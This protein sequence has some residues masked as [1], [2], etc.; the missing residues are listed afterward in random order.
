MY[1]D[2][3][4]ER[5]YAA[6][7]LNADNESPPVVLVHGAAMD[8]TVWVYHTR[9]FLH[10]GHNV[11]A[12]D[13]PG[14]GLSG[15]EPRRGIEDMASWLGG[16]LDTLGVGTVAL[17]GHSMGALVALELASRLGTRVSRLA[18]LGAAVPMAVSPEL[19]AE[20]EQDSVTARDMMVIW[21]H[22]SAA[23]IGGNAVAGIAIINSALRLLER[24]R[25]GVLFADLSAC[26][27][28]VAGMQAAA[29]VSAS[30]TLICGQE[31]RMTP[32]KAAR[33]LA[34]GMPAAR[35]ELIPDCGHIMMGERPEATHR[36]LVTALL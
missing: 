34:E 15:G 3:D 2:I 9:Y 21:G 7:R 20:A 4:G 26:N 18:L 25:R 31:D 33:G 23:Q 12:I 16:C 10:A 27:D 24:A 6:G 8:H 1:I 5:I 19:L 11:L 32:L 30:T 14:H 36:H 29:A 22:G 28:Y 13:L 35:I 17:A